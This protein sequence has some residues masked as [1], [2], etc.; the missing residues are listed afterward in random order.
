MESPE[1]YMETLWGHWQ[2]L[3]LDKTLTYSPHTNRCNESNSIAA[4]ES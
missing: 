3:E 2:P 4:G 1:D